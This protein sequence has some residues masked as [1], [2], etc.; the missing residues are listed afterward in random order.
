MH[1]LG[2][3]KDQRTLWN[4]RMKLTTILMPNCIPFEPPARVLFG[5]LISPQHEYIS[6]TPNMRATIS[7]LVNISNHYNGQPI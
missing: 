7:F 5:I 4:T 3:V 2:V 6:T 1:Y